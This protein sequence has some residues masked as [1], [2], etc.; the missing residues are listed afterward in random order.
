VCVCVCVCVLCLCVSSLYLSYSYSN[1]YGFTL[2]FLLYF[3]IPCTHYFWFIFCFLQGS[4]KNLIALFV[5]LVYC[6][7]WNI[8]VFYE[9]IKWFDF[10][11]FGMV[12]IQRAFSRHAP[13]AWRLWPLHP[14]RTDRVLP[15]SDCGTSV[16][17]PPHVR[18]HRWSQRRTHLSVQHNA[19]WLDAT[20]SGLDLQ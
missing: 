18:T 2:S 13:V 7:V 12:S 16:H 1:S 10:I 17:V 14:V 8:F 4:C 3:C 9:R 11:W 5:Q 20:Q 15:A 6:H 19:L